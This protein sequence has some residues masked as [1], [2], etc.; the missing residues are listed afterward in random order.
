MFGALPPYLSFKSLVVHKETSPAVVASGERLSEKVPSV[1][2]MPG[3][4][5]HV[6]VHLNSVHLNVT[7]DLQKKSFQLFQTI[8]VL[9]FS[10]GGYLI[11]RKLRFVVPQGR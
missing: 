8:I 5:N 6:I 11:Q 1:N 9:L 10:N 3:L 4:S 7:F 2:R